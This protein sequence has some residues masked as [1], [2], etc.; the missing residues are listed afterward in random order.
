V[1]ERVRRR[2][3]A[4][5][6][7]GVELPRDRRHRWGGADNWDLRY[8]WLR[9]GAAAGLALI[10]YGHFD[11]ADGFKHWLISRVGEPASQFRPLYTVDGM[12][13]T[14]EQD[15][16]HL[17]GYAGSR[18]IRV[19]NSA[20]A[21]VQ[22][23]VFGP[24][25]K[26][27]LAIT[28]NHQVPFLDDSLMP[29]LVEA[30]ARRWRSRDHGIWEDRV[31]PRHHVYSKVMCW[32]TV[33]R[34]CQLRDHF[35][36]PVPENWLQL[37]DEIAAEVVDRGWNVKVGAYTAAYG[38]DELDASA[39][40][41]GLSGLLPPDDPRFVATVNAVE[42]ELR[43][44]PTVLRYLSLDGTPTPRTGFNVC[45]A[46][47]VDAYRL[48]GRRA[49]AQELL[50]RLM[51]CAGPTGGLSSNYDP[52]LGMSL[53]NYPHAASI[54]WLLIAAKNLEESGR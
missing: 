23:D 46:W 31:E 1:W 10:R 44:G 48:V 34:A 52:E 25:A 20:G 16:A 54:A 32:V 38:S 42:R 14:R 51:E 11:E 24:I 47:L 6:R 13:V 30:V 2:R 45:T 50:D 36:E 27:V 5:V 37:R 9:D 15:I 40:W 33:D 19:G 22:A 17:P 4:S 53:G 3:R 39:L 29:D 26:M 8:C 28:Q 7:T 35:E 21:Q 12:E 41:I 43:R 18:P 49:D